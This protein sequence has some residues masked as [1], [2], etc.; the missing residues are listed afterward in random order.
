[1]PQ[2]NPEFFLS[3]LFWLIITFSFLLIFLWRVSLPRINLVLEKRESKINNDLE[4]AKE[5]QAEAEKIQNAI[6]ERLSKTYE[7]A[8][9]LLKK[10]NL[11]LQDNSIKELSILEE[12]ISNK[13]TEASSKIENNKKEYLKDID[14]KIAE[15]TK[16]TISKLISIPINDDEIIESVLKTKEKN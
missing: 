6:E 10:E 8:G 3:Q 2:L 9:N 13:I 5:N 12:E 14:K 16:L 4:S 1:M 15:I 11:K 7:E